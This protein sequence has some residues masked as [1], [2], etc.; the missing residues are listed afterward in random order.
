MGTY[1]LELDDPLPVLDVWNPAGPQWRA[2]TVTVSDDTRRL[3]ALGFAAGRDEAGSRPAS[4]LIGCR[5][6]RDASVR[7]LRALFEES[8]PFR[9]SGALC[10]EEGDF[11][12][13]R[14]VGDEIL[15]HV[16]R[17]S[18]EALR[19][20]S[21]HDMVQ[22][23]AVWKILCRREWRRHDAGIPPLKGALR[24]PPAAHH[25]GEPA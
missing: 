7:H 21:G 20:L 19:N 2:M 23:R 1:A 11:I 4:E 9:A 18:Q 15:V 10:F 12:L 16:G 5:G 14:H 3:I 24:P 8:M 22:I 13:T 25:T 17:D 6:I